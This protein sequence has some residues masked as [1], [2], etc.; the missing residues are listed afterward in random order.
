LINRGVLYNGVVGNLL[1]K[2]SLIDF[3]FSGWVAYSITIFLV[4]DDLTGS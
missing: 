4:I 3:N 2:L 1:T